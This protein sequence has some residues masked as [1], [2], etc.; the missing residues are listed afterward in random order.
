MYDLKIVF[1]K[2]RKYGLSL[3]LKKILFTMEEGK[4]LW[5]IISKDGIRIDLACVQEIQQIV[6]P[7]NKKE[8][9][10]FNGKMNLL[11]RFVPN[12]VEHLREMKNMFKKDGEVKWMEEV[13]KSFNLVNLALSLAP[14]LVS[15]DYTHGFILFSFALEHIMAIV[16]LQKRDDHERPIAFF[17]R[18]IRDATLK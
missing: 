5:H 10:S 6:L 2:C 14:I 9:Q 13:V 17:T 1:Q 12:L 4:L 7:R 16:L 15:P 18:A 3:N 11:H 8:I